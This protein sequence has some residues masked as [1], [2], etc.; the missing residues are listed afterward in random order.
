MCVLSCDRSL[1]G[2]RME[3]TIEQRLC[4]LEK[5]VAELKADRHVKKQAPDKDWTSTIGWAKDDPGFDEMI[6]LGRRYR[7][8][9]RK[10]PKT[11]ARARHKSSG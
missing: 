1:E 2:E 6:E 11:N 3:Q 9:Q 8:R 7:E 10:R 4:E 5:E